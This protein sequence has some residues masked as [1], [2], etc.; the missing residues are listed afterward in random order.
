MSITVP[1]AV[2]RGDDALLKCNYDLENDTLYSVK[3][4][5]GSREFYRYLPKENPAMKLFPLGGIIVDVSLLSHTVYYCIQL[6]SI[7]YLHYL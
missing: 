1:I 6:Y 5:K 3:W 7:S 2:R 4:Y